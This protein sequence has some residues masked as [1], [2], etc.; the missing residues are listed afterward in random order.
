MEGETPRTMDEQTYGGLGEVADRLLPVRHYDISYQESRFASLN[1]HFSGDC[2]NHC[3]H[4]HSKALWHQRPSDLISIRQL[5]S[6]M[7]E[8]TCSG[9]AEAL[10]IL[11]TDYIGKGSDIRDLVGFARRIGMIVIVFTGLNRETAIA[12]Y[13][14]DF[15]VCGPYRGGA[16][17]DHKVF[18]EMTRNGYREIS[19]G[20]YFKR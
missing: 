6:V 19:R 12:T 18:L 10:G 8:N 20:E 16:W 2:V 13:D 5:C 1:L 4:C 3:P 15:I 7:V 11:G 9:I 17:F 14:A